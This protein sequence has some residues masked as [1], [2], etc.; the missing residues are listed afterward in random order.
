M[1]TNQILSLD[2][3]DEENQKAIQKALRQI[4]PLSKY[5]DECEIPFSAL[6]KAVTVMCKKYLLH[7]RDIVADARANDENMIWRAA[8]ID[9][10]TLRLV[11]NVYGISLYEVLAKT[12]IGLY[13]EV[14]RGAKLR[15]K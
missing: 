8:L 7:I 1:T 5:S 15:A 4:K 10:T 9:E 14:K 6:E 11:Y 3:R 12:A 2:Y 13:A